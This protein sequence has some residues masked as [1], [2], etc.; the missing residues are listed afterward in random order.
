MPK[1]K[2]DYGIDSPNAVI[3]ML[4]IGIVCITSGLFLVLPDIGNTGIKLNTA[5]IGYGIPFLVSGVLMLIYSQYGKFR[6]RDKILSLLKL[7]GHENILDVG[8]GKG[9]LMI[10]A[11]KK[12][13]T[14]KVSGIDIWNKKC[15]TGNTMDNAQLNAKLENVTGKIELLNQDARKLNFSD[16]YFDV[17][18]SNRCINHIKIREERE[19]ACREIYRVLKPNGTIIISDIKFA[20]EYS[21]YFNS[22]GASAQISRPYFFKTFPASRIVKVKKP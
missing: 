5:L 13:T 8:T 16:G 4:I 2:P 15:L 22:I 18:I 19:N 7:Q 21:Q 11:A 6:H 12:L 10:G 3:G 14:G 9:L 20:K 1:T 17:I